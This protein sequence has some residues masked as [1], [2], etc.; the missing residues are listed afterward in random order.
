MKNY[1]K[2]KVPTFK[3]DPKKIDTYISLRLKNWAYCVAKKPEKAEMVQNATENLRSKWQTY[4]IILS[5]GIRMFKTVDLECAR[6]ID[7]EVRML[8]R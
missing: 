3:P 6:N 7:L 5:V 1:K 8:C 2:T 4:I